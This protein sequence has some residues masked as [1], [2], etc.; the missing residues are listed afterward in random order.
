MWRA[1]RQA[2]LRELTLRPDSLAPPPPTR[3]SLKAFCVNLN[4]EARTARIDPL[5]GRANEIARIVQILARRKKNNPLLVGDS[6]V[7]V[8][9]G[10][11]LAAGG[12]NC[13]SFM[14]LY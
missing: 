14:C 4:E 9:V 5:V 10:A 11:G 12:A 13:S 3:I 1:N 2:A 6:G 8:P 7:G